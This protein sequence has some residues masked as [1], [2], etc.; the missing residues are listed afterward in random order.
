MFEF[1]TFSST[2]SILH[3]KD[4]TVSSNSESQESSSPPDNPIKCDCIHEAILLNSEFYFFAAVSGIIDPKAGDKSNSITKLNIRYRLWSRFII[5]GLLFSIIWFFYSAI[6]GFLNT[7]NSASLRTLNFITNCAFALQAIVVFPA[8]GYTRAVIVAKR[9]VN[10]GDFNQN[11]AYSVNLSWNFL[12]FWIL[13]SMIFV[14]LNGYASSEYTTLV[15]NVLSQIFTFLIIIPS[16]YFLMGIL[17]LLVYEQRVSR[18]LMDEV[19]KEINDETLTVDKYLSVRESMEMRDRAAPINLMLFSCIISVVAGLASLF[20]L[21]MN[22]NDNVAV[23]ILYQIFVLIAVYG[24]PYAVILII[25]FEI[26]G[27]NE[28]AEKIPSTIAKYKWQSSLDQSMRFSLYM[29]TKEYPLG[30]MII[31]LRPSKFELIT[32]V[33]SSIVGVVFAA[34]WAIFFS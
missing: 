15:A 16:N 20:W 3:T 17:C 29:A 24:R 28:R 8:I 11:F 18:Q 12:R 34:F 22:E 21:F 25:L 14:C 1:F 32:Q 10:Y 9:D 2:N 7:S 4:L 23:D 13:L 30:S 33:V 19:L 27:V 26:V 31:N 6:V 5:V